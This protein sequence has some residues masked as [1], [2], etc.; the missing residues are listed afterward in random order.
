MVRYDLFTS[1]IRHRKQIHDLYCLK[2][3]AC[4]A[5]DQVENLAWIVVL[6]AS[7]VGIILNL[8]WFVDRYLIALDGPFECALVVEDA[9]IG[10]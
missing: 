4:D 10:F 9:F 5:F 1:F 6:L 8:R 3:F 7:V 2:T